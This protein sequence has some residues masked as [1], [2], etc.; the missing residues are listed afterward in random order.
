MLKRG[1]DAILARWVQVFASK[2]RAADMGRYGWTL[3]HRQVKQCRAVEGHQFDVSRMKMPRYSFA[4]LHGVD[5]SSF[6]AEKDCER[7]PESNG[8]PE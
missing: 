4:Y 2:R 7:Y 3:I 8:W 6:P 1:K 5:G